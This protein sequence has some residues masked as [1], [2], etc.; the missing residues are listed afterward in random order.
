MWAFGFGV[1]VLVI[2][3]TVVWN[4]VGPVTMDVDKRYHG[5]FREGRFAGKKLDV[6]GVLLVKDWIEN[7][8]TPSQHAF[9]VL[10]HQLWYNAFTVGYELKLWIE[11]ASYLPSEKQYAVHM[12]NDVVFL[13]IEYSGKNRVLKASFTVADL[14]AALAPYVVD[15]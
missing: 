7:R 10:A 1:V 8:T 14:E 9:E 15:Q 4:V 6:E 13:R 3:A 5:L 2:I 11:P 12:V